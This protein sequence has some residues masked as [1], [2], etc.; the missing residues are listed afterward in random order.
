[1]TWGIEHYRFW[2]DQARGGLSDIDATEG[3]RDIGY[4]TDLQ[5]NWRIRPRVIWAMEY[6]VFTPGKAYAP[7]ANSQEKVF[8]TSLTFIF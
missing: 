2:K 1:M 5:M 6:G 4:E 8:T 3:S 7:S